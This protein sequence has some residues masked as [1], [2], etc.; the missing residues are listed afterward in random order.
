MIV[1]TNSF[2]HTPVTI[3]QA[4]ISDEGYRFPL[5]WVEGTA[6]Q[7]EKIQNILMEV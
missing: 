7:Q 1:K 3:S 2:Y 5:P 4:H 6:G